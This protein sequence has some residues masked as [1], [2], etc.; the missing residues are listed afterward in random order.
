MKTPSAI[1][2]QVYHQFKASHSLEG[3]EKAHYHIWK[4]VEAKGIDKKFL[5]ILLEYE[6]EQMKAE[7]ANGL[8]LLHI[9]KGAIEGWGCRIPKEKEQQKIANCLSSIDELITAQ[10]QKLDTLKTHKKGLMQ[11]LFP[12]ADK[13]A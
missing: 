4:V 2:L 3:F 9:T 7:S 6:T 8:G 12:A 5:F 1:S 10:S 13:R 11:A